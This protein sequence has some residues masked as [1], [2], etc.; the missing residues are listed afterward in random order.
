MQG[1]IGNRMA[2]VS[3]NSI[4][5]TQIRI[6]NLVKEIT[7]KIDKNPICKIELNEIEIV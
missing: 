7:E 2:I 6:A 1:Q 3:A 5:V 4:D